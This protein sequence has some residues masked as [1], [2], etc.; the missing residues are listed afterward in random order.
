MN[1]NIKNK[2]ESGALL[3]EILVAIGVGVTIA[4]V[5]GVGVE[6]VKSEYFKPTPENC[7]AKYY[8]S[9]TVVNA[10]AGD[11]VEVKTANRKKLRGVL[12]CCLE[13]MG[14]GY[15]WDFVVSKCLKNGSNS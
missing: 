9:C 10:V 4:I 7:E 13:G 14:V 2:N 3:V 15:T 11:S 12:Y 8:A 5:G 1:I 6:W